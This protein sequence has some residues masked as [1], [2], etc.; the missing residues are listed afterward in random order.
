MTSAVASHRRSEVEFR[1]GIPQGIVNTAEIMAQLERGSQWKNAGELHPTAGIGD[2]VNVNQFTDEPWL[3]LTVLGPP[4]PAG[5][6]TVRLSARITARARQRQEYR[7]LP[8][9]LSTS[10]DRYGR[11]HHLW[12]SDPP[13]P[14]DPGAEDSVDGLPLA[15]NQT[16][17]GYPYFR[18]GYG[19]APKTPV[20]PPSPP[21]GTVPTCWSCPLM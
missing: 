10:P 21:S 16:K 14:A 2:T 11:I 20:E 1:D 9:Q 5:E 3:A 4:E 8:L 12:E 18:A 13:G 19:A 6:N 7:S 17:E 15:Q